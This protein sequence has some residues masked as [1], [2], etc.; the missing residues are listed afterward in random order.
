[1]K[2]IATLLGK[3][4]KTLALCRYYADIKRQRLAL[5][6]PNWLP[7]RVDTCVALLWPNQECGSCSIQNESN[8]K[9]CP[10]GDN[11]LKYSK[12][13]GYENTAQTVARTILRLRDSEHSSE[14]WVSELWVSGVLYAYTNSDSAQPRK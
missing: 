10:K 13:V 4:L 2:N 3:E 1:M 7:Y 14:T 5:R 9:M 8:I 12:T 6:E 11:T